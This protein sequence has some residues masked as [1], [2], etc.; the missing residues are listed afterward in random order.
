[1]RLPPTIEKELQSVESWMA[2]LPG[3]HAG[4]PRLR[5][6]RYAIEQFMKE[7]GLKW[8]SPSHDKL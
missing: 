3:Q 8:D 2:K 5:D 1:M 7:N 6:L 4:V